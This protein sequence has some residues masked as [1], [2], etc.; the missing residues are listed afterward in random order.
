[1][2]TLELEREQPV[3]VA[4]D[5]TRA[6]RLRYAGAALVLLGC[7]WLV[8]LG[9]GMLGFGHLPGLSLPSVVRAADPAPPEQARGTVHSSS[10]GS[11]AV[12]SPTSISPRAD[13]APA[14]RRVSRPQRASRAKPAARVTRPTRARTRTAPPATA[15]VQAVQPPVAATPAPAPARQGW[16]RSGWTAPPG[17]SR[18]TEPRAPVAPPGQTRRQAAPAETTT[19]TTPEAAPLPPGQQKKPDEPKPKG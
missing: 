8:A 5:G 10:Q 3:F 11:R 14:A 9:V 4:A 1:M 13:A 2:T 16:A 15:P 6:R 12:A 17:Q 7:L 18:Q 19:P